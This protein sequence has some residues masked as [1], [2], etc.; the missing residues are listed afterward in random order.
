M[1][2]QI[3]FVMSMMQSPLLMAELSLSTLIFYELLGIK[4]RFR[5]MMGPQQI[6]MLQKNLVTLQMLKFS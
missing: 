6:K 2:E 5:I 3:L 1:K 4:Y